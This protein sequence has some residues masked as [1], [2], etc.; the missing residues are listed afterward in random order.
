MA[1]N[2]EQTGKTA[3]AAALGIA[4]GALGI[5]AGLIA[6]IFGGAGVLLFEGGSQIMWLSA[7]GVILG[8]AGI[9]GGAMTRSNPEMATFIMAI[10]GFGGF[11]A[12]S[13][14]WILPGAL[15]IIGAVIAWSARPTKQAAPAR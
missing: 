11:V 12:I 4:G 2:F 7:L 1:S 9:V 10:T 5:I 14:F 6:M 8:I 3:T 15:L 13:L